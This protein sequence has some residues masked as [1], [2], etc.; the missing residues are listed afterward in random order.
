MAWVNRRESYLVWVE[1]CRGV[2]CVRP[3]LGL[4]TY[5][6][7]IL[8][9]CLKNWKGREE[10]IFGSLKGE[11]VQLLLIEDKGFQLCP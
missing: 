8:V 7:G 5:H 1:P 2:L 4:Q 6:R 10:E 11:T 9:F 3:P